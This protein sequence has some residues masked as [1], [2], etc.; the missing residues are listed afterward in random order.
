MTRLTVRTC[1]EHHCQLQGVNCKSIF[2]FKNIIRAA[3][4]AQE[5]IFKNINYEALLSLLTHS[6]NMKKKLG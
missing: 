3:E 6:I 5:C 4:V 1:Y 2:Q